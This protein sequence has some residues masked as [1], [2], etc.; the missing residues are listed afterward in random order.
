MNCRIHLFPIP[1]PT[2]G[3]ILETILYGAVSILWLKE[4]A[5]PTTR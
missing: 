1:S 5:I 2:P 4:I 3:A